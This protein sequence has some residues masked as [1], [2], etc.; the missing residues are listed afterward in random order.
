MIHI[1]LPNFSMLDKIRTNQQNKSYSLKPNS[2]TCYHVLIWAVVICMLQPE[3]VSTPK[4]E[5]VKGIL[6][7][8]FY[9]QLNL[10]I[11]IN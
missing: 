2:N 11:P 3:S 4:R 8:N 1:G 6:N 5:V 9:L 7:F 10:R